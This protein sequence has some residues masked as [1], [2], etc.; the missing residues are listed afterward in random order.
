MPSA[1]VAMRRGH[2]SVVDGAQSQYELQFRTIHGY[3]RA[4]VHTG[5]G[6]VILLI[7]GIG[8]NSET[9]RDLIPSLA[10]NYTVV[11][12]DLL[13]HGSSDKPRA[14]YAIAAYACGMRDLLGVLGI[15]EVTVVGHSL[16]GGVAMQFAYQFPERCQRLI[17][18]SSGG[19]GREVH[20]MLRLAA[21]PGTGPLLP[22]LNAPPV[23][24]V[25][26][27]VISVV[28]RLGT[29]LGRDASDLV[30]TFDALPDATARS[31]FLRTLRAAVDW[32]GQVITLL[33]RCYL[34]K[35]MPTLLVWGA[36]DPII[37]VEHGRVA[38]LAMPGSRLE[39]FGD[40][41]HFPHH[42]DPERFLAVLREFVD[43]T[44]PATYGTH[45]WRELLRAGRP[46]AADDLGVAIAEA[47]IEAGP[48]SAT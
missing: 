37:P 47:T 46:D 13:G 4:F 23:R 12:P 24:F 44:E 15:D 32:R 26:R 34:T 33:D 9:W 30:R 18:V 16:G 41:G 25:G 3:R 43:T 29:D 36:R 1:E 45:E 8:D 6:P 11:A 48:R 10:R 21:T 39:V 20:P 5:E 42:T 38:H 27:S 14:D 7:H 28:K 19:V 40:A 17:L 2:L 22:L 31:A 35:G